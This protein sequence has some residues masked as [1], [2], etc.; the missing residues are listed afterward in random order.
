MDEDSKKVAE[1]VKKC[2]SEYSSYV[3]AGEDVP[4]AFLEKK[5]W[6]TKE[7]FKNWKK[8]AKSIIDGPSAGKGDDADEREEDMAHDSLDNSANMSGPFNA[9]LFCEHGMCQLVSYLKYL[10]L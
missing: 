8:M 10:T 2:D 1:I 9:D 5:C 4:D 3:K 6:I 7:N